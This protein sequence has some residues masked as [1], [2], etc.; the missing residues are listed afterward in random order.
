[1]VAAAGRQGS[2]TLEVTFARALPGIT[3]GA[4]SPL[5]WVND[6]L[7]GPGFLL[8]NNTIQSRR[9]GALI[10][11]RD[12][13]IMGNRF[14]DNPGPTILLLNDDDYDNPHE[15]RMGYMPRNIVIADN[16]FVRGSRC[17]PDPYHAGT[18]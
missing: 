16:S 17:V 3:C 2:T 7:S 6:A 10:M 1:V 18:A 9:F 12:G 4:G 15:S 11:G 5:Q 8:R 14:V 13:A